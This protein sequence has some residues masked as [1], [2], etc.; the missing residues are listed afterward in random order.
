MNIVKAMQRIGWRFGEAKAFTPNQND[1]DAYNYLVDFVE[2]KQQEQIK[3]N[4]LFA[5]LFCYAFKNEIQFYKCPKHAQRKI[6]EEL[7][8]PIQYHYDSV[9]EMLNDVVYNAFLENKGFPDKHPG[10]L[11]EKEIQFKKELIK[12]YEK[13]LTELLKGKWDIE[14]VTQSL[15]NTITELLNRFP[16]EI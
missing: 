16:D 10:T 8:L 9:L 1:A 7:E 2:T 12:N 13:E 3:K 11:T 4:L 6:Y 15:N 5:K 14:I